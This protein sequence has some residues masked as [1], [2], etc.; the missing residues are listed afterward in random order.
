MDHMDFDEGWMPFVEELGHLGPENFDLSMK[1]QLTWQDM[2][3]DVHRR[4]S[5][6]Q[7]NN[8][9]D[10]RIGP[11]NEWSTPKKDTWVPIED[12]EKE[13]T[14][15]GGTL[16]VVASM[17]VLRDAGQRSPLYTQ[18]AFELDGTVLAETVLG[19]QDQLYEGASM[20]TGLEGTR[21]GVLLQ[22][23]FPISPGTHIVRAVLKA[24]EGP[25]RYAT[26]PDNLNNASDPY[27]YEDVRVGSREL[28]VIEDL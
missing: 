12:L 13:F 25:T 15:Y 23:T 8:N 18:F 1:S 16:T 3:Q 19:D 14:S 27:P 17:Q 7:E 26:N 5:T 9:D 28:I 11:P 2:A 24:Q 4:F 10:V 6:E 21:Y 20:E 22:A